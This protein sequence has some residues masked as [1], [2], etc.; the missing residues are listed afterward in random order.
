MDRVFIRHVAK[1]ALTFD[2]Y[3]QGQIVGWSELKNSSQRAYIWQNGK[4]TDLNG[5]LGTGV[6]QTVQLANGI[7]NAGHIIGSGGGQGY[8]LISKP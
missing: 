4:M 3:D 6:K 8:L 2:P 1:D 7:N 5:L